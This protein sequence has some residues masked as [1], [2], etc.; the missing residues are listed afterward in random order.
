MAT[1]GVRELKNRLSEFLRRVTA[2]EDITPTHPRRPPAR[3]RPPASPAAAQGNPRKVCDG[4]PSRARGKLHLAVAVPLPDP[5][6]GDVIF[7]AWDDP[8]DAAAAREGFSLLRAR[9][10]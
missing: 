7:G 6:G 1:V 4:L 8:L 9:R 10:R 5:V 2:G 3:P